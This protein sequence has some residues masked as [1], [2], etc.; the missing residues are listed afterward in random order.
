MASI[1]RFLAKCLKLTVNESKSGVVKT[2][3]RK[4]LGFRFTGGKA[5][6]LT[7]RVLLQKTPPL[8]LH[9]L[10]TETVFESQQRFLGEERE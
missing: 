4:F 1:E 3:A 5:C 7:A 9:A 8:L 2:S 6:S 10:G